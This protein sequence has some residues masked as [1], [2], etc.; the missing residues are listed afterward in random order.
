[1]TE[2]REYQ[3][4]SMLLDQEWSVKIFR[5]PQCAFGL[6]WTHLNVGVDYVT[7]MNLYNLIF[8]MVELLYE[9]YYTNSCI[10]AAG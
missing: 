4:E 6:D 3:R 5:F 1:M 8:Q 9:L 10:G 7:L 2:W